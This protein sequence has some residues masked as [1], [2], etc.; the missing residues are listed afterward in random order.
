MYKNYQLFTKQQ[1]IRLVQIE[2]S[3]RQQKKWVDIIKIWLGK[4][5]KT[6][7]EKE[8]MLVSIFSIPLNVFKRLLPDDC[9]VN[10]KSSFVFEREQNIPEKR[11]NAYTSNYNHSFSLN[12]FSN[13]L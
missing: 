9:L 6:L 12:A 4:G 7:W 10:T 1:N 13:I 11:E 3:C 8:R 2:S 5:R